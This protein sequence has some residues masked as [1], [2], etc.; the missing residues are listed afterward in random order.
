MTIRLRQIALVAYKLQ[1]VIDDLRAVFGL[2]VC[3]VDEGVATFGLENSLLPVGT[4]FLEVVAPVRENTAGGRYLER[5]K[6][7]GGYMVICQC[8]G[9]ATQLARR[10]RAL[11]LGIRVAWERESADY[12]ILQLHPADT[13]GSFFE[14]DWDAR[15]EPEGHWG[16]AGGADWTRAVRTEVVSAFVA[17]ELQSP[18]PTPLAERWSAITEIPLVKNDEGQ[19]ELPLEN[20]RLRFVAAEDGRGEGLGGVDLRVVDRERLL[21]AAEQRGCRVSDDQVL[22]CGTRFYLT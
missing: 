10:A 7:D 13:G 12:H 2:E 3:F 4:D 5:R 19:L 1:P 21:A 14:I 6:G 8:D 15:E 11:E 20:A 22:I 16:P 17:V 18:D 9:H